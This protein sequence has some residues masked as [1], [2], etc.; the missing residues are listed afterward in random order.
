MDAESEAS[1]F[2]RAALIV[3]AVLMLYVLSIGPVNRYRL[4]IPKRA[5]WLLSAFSPVWWG[6][7]HC[8]PLDKALLWYLAIWE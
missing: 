1:P 6:A 5:S 2:A 4:E 3:I 8:Q 7:D